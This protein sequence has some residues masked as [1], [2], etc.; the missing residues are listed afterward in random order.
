[1]RLEKNDFID[2]LQRWHKAYKDYITN[3]GY[4]KN[5]IQTYTRLIEHF[6]EYSRGFQDEMSIREINT[7]Y[8]TSF[9]SYMEN[10]ALKNSKNKLKQNGLSKSTKSLYVRILKNFFS[11]VGDNNDEL[12]LFEP[13]FKK[14]KI[15]DYQQKEEKTVYLNENEVEK[16]INALSNNIKKQNNYN[17]YRNSLLI[18]LMLYAGLRISEA[19]KVKVSDFREYDEQTMKIKIIGKG[20]REQFAFIAKAIIIDELDYIKRYKQEDSEL[21]DN[22]LIMV[23]RSGK[24]LQRQNAYEIISKIYRKANIFKTGVHL[25]RHTF[26]MR[27]T[28][29]TKNVLVVKKALR[30]ASINSTMVYAR[31]EESDL[32]EAIEKK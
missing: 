32:A 21:I 12:Y 3:I 4:S 9:L 28:K 23:T 29:R 17:A 25:L 18:K 31:A 6:I 19:L 27:M 1:M 5:T 11:F 8:I 26:A 16:L 22:E 7:L 20:N 10:N 13:I 15:R 30:H 2:D 14:I 24:P